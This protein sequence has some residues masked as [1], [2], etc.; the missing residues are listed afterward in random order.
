M[1]APKKAKKAAT[2]SVPAGGN[3][4]QGQQPG[5]LCVYQDMARQLTVANKG[6]LPASLVPIAG[7]LK[8]N[9]EA[10]HLKVL[11]EAYSK[12]FSLHNVPEGERDHLPLVDQLLKGS[13]GVRKEHFLAM[14]GQQNIR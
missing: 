9:P 7:K 5:E 3:A 8:T 10:A 1:T 2:S 13:G 14:V 11:C 6:N 4:Q 12:H